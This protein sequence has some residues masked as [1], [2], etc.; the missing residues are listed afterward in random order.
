METSSPQFAESKDPEHQQQPQQSQQQAMQLQ[1]QSSFIGQPQ[2]QRPPSPFPPLNLSGTTVFEWAT[3][4]PAAAAASIIPSTNHQDTNDEAMAISKPINNNNN[5]H[6]GTVPVF[7]QG[8]GTCINPN[9]KPRPPAIDTSMASAIYADHN[10]TN[11]SHPIASTTSDA[12]MAFTPQH[13]QQYQLMDPKYQSLF[14]LQTAAE[15][16]TVNKAIEQ[17]NTLMHE[18]LIA[19]AQSKSVNALDI[20]IEEARDDLRRKSMQEHAK[21]RQALAKEN[22]KLQIKLAQQLQWRSPDYKLDPEEEQRLQDLQDRL[23]AMEE[24]ETGGPQDEKVTQLTARQKLQLA[25]TQWKQPFTIVHLDPVVEKRRKEL[26]EERRKSMEERKHSKSKDNARLKQRLSR[27]QGKLSSHLDASVE[28]RRLDLVEERRKSLEQLREAQARPAN[29]NNKTTTKTTRTTYKSPTNTSLDNSIEQRRRELE[30][31]RR[32]KDE[33]KRLELRA[34]TKAMKE[35]LNRVKGREQK[36]LD[37]ATKSKRKELQEKRAQEKFRQEQDRKKHSSDF[38][39]R[40][41]Q[42]LESDEYYDNS[43]AAT[44]KRF[45]FDHDER[46]QLQKK[47]QQEAIQK[48]KEELETH[49]K[50][51][52]KR[53]KGVK[54]GRT[55]KSLDAEVEALRKDL[56]Q[57][58]ISDNQERTEKI[59]KQNMEF[60]SRV[61]NPKTRG[62]SLSSYLNNGNDDN[63]QEARSQT[64]WKL[65]MEASERRKTLTAENAKIKQRLSNIS[66]KDTKS[67]SGVVQSLRSERE[68]SRKQAVLQKH[69]ELMQHQKTYKKRLSDVTSRDCMKL[70]EATQA[71]RTKRK[72][73]RNSSVRQKQKEL[74]Q[75]KANLQ[76]MVENVKSPIQQMLSTTTTSPSL[77]FSKFRPDTIVTPPPPPTITTATA[78]N[79]NGSPFQQSAQLPAGIKLFDFQTMSNATTP[80]SL[81][82]A[83]NKANSSSEKK[84]LGQKRIVEA[85]QRNQQLRDQNLKLRKRLAE[86]TAASIQKLESTITP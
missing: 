55:K 69:K 43:P 44:S 2:H 52:F 51:F 38:R 24:E 78:V 16:E 71:V 66:G 8:T 53:T 3:V 21:K 65:K 76:K 79:N 25:Q 9:S 15:Q 4:D 39:K 48:R 35:R 82:E 11:K 64:A 33:R 59:R 19:M 77:T 18:H 37:K 17:Q 81:I 61:K 58:S 74:A 7:Q 1:L 20:S 14:F 80:E 63:V 42:F 5:V 28:Q 86:A 6:N 34:H 57:K 27:V 32:Q 60:H 68:Q 13:Q 10:D 70:N 84:R 75:H 85:C 54:R 41:S 46:R 30:Q 36:S 47:R 23:D 83:A 31:Q 67:L 22:A 26:K 50:E 45:S 56:A 40:M 49:K 29:N 12:T 62:F 72:A 73:K